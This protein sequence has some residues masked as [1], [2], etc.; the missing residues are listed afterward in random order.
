MMVNMGAANTLPMKKWV[1]SHSLI[2]KEK[3]DEYISGTNGTVF[4]IVGMTSINILLAPTLELD[5]A[6]V[7][8]C[9]GNLYQGLLGCD[10]LCGH[11]EVLGVAIITLH[12]P[13]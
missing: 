12:R 9:S 4:R 6:N 2:I 5:I 13:D 11:N 10:L 3:V 1:D 7:A 8:I